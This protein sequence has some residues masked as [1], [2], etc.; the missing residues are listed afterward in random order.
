M[1]QL[2]VNDQA[3]PSYSV[4][5]GILRYKDRI[6]I[7][8]NTDLRTKI[9]S[10]LHSSA[11]GGHSRIT[12][13][14]QR[15]KRIFHWPSLKKSI[16]TFVTQCVVC[17]RAKVEHCHYLGLLSPLPIP[18]LAWTFISMD[19]VEC[20]KKSGTK[21][22]ILV[23]LDRHTKYAH[24]IP[25]SHPFTAQDVAQLFIDNIFKLHGP[26][27]PITDRDMM[28]TSKLWQDIQIY[29]NIPAL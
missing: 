10:S 21:N 17:Q 26:P 22:V 6:C 23:V 7:S 29:E 3:V 19:C 5:S 1:Q 14:Y 9:L 15:I 11:I 12:P 4:H 18:N 24:F 27:V 8:S 13:T 2:L 16:E 25:L 20:L 28:F